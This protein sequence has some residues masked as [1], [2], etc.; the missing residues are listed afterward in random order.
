MP[1]ISSQYPRL[2]A[3]P[4]VDWQGVSPVLLNFLESILERTGKRA[5]ITSGRRSEAY[6]RQVGGAQKSKH[7]RGLAVDAVVDG[8]PITLAV[9]EGY[10][11]RY[12]IRSGNQPGFF[13]GQP[14]PVHVDLPD[15]T[16]WGQTLVTRI[17]QRADR[18]DVEPEAAL[19]VASVEGGFVG[20]V[21]DQGTSF[22]PFQL[23]QGGAMPAG[24]AGSWAQSPAGVDYALQRIGDVA[25]GLRGEAAI[26]EIVYKFE[27]PQDPE[28]EVENATQRY[29]AAKAAGNGRDPNKWISYNPK[30]EPIVDLTPGFD[31]PGLPDLGGPWGAIKDSLGKIGSF[32]HIIVWPFTHIKRF[33]QILVGSIL[34]VIGVIMMAKGTNTGQ[35]AQQVATMVALKGK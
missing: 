10:F 24:K 28:R 5:T 4:N 33:G 35:A 12:G 32:F 23:H 7:I 16:I 19:A 20:K 27:R 1:D 13:R 14:D 11:D 26:R 29:R 21:G 34:V 15:Q 3:N 30:G 2:R 17:A 8:R 31:P 9:P 6:N 25:G 22:G 18:E